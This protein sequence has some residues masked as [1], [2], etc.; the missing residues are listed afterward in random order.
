MAGGFVQAL[1]NHSRE[2]QK[3]EGSQAAEFLRML[4]NLRDVLR[5]RFLAIGS[6][7]Q[8]FDVYLLNRVIAETETGILT[9]RHK[10]DTLY[11]RAQDKAVNLSI[12]HLGDELERLSGAFDPETLSVSIDAAKVLADPVQKLLANHFDTSVARYGGDLLNRVRQRIFVGLRAGDTLGEMAKDVAGESGPLG[13]VGRSFGERLVRTEVS[14]AY[15]AAQHSGMIEAKQSIPGLQKV[16]LHVGSFICK[17]CNPIHGTMRPMD[18]T[19]TV[20]VGRKART[21][22]HAPAHPQCTCRVSAMKP[23][24]RNAMQNLGY[25]DKQDPEEQPTL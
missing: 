5:G 19:W 12:E 18:G 7:D 25:L 24:W 13:T 9:L 11:S 10:A 20:M 6:A 1:R 22:A 15:G 8:T 3:L 2:V 17:V 16:W 14:Q 23:G 21:V 4:E